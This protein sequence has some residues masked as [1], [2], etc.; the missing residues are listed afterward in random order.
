MKRQDSLLQHNKTSLFFLTSN[1]ENY[2]N[3]L[4]IWAA[5]YIFCLAWGFSKMLAI[6]MRI[7]PR[8]Q[9]SPKKR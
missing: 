7:K 4:S 6:P 8:K 2:V 5:Y 9:V 1:N 3:E